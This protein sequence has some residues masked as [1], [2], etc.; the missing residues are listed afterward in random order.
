MFDIHIFILE[1]FS[2]KKDFEIHSRKIVI[3]P[4]K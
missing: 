3:D 2:C 1:F 4:T